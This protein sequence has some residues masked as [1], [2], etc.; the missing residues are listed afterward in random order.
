MQLDV[1][2]AMHRAAMRGNVGAMKAFLARK[3]DEAVKRRT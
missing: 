3:P 2:V 1:L